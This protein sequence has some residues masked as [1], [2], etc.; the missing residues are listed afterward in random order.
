MIY[1]AVKI[2]I[3]C[4]TSLSWEPN[5]WPWHYLHRLG[6]RNAVDVHVRQCD[7]CMWLIYWKKIYRYYFFFYSLFKEWGFCWKF[8]KALFSCVYRS[9]VIPV[10]FITVLWF[11]SSCR[12]SLESCVGRLR[13]KKCL[14]AHI[15]P[16]LLMRLR[17]LS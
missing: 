10:G 12:V 15:S 17:S 9:G 8:S 5:P 4:M 2:F 14:F 11:S 1:S 7:I 13:V 6:Y 16:T 3:Q